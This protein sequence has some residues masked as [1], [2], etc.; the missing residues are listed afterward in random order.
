MTEGTIKKKM[1]KDTLQD[2]IKLLKLYNKADKYSKEMTDEEKR[3]DH[4]KIKKLEAGIEAIEADA[5][6]KEAEVNWDVIRSKKTGMK[7][8]RKKGH[9]KGEQH[10]SKSYAERLQAY[11]KSLKDYPPQ[12][13]DLKRLD[14]RGVGMQHGRYTKSI[15]KG[16]KVGRGMGKALRGGGSVTRG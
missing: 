16:G 14:K 3:V 1:L 7:T 15:K 13:K 12:K 6:A 5:A 4:E 8:L 11:N 2:K 9:H 10:G